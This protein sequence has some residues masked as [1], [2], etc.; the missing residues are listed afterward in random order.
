[1]SELGKR[2]SFNGETN[3]NNN[4]NKENENKV[5]EKEG[6]FDFLNII[7]DENTYNNNEFSVDNF[8]DFTKNN[9]IISNNDLFDYNLDNI[10]DN[11]T[12]TNFYDFTKFNNNPNYDIKNN[13][14]INTEQIENNNIG[15]LLF[16]DE[17]KDNE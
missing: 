17:N 16:F 6:I 5:V 13:N 12:T 11:S 7:N 1:M 2:K 9:N 15:N 14:T 8:F 3:L 10:N 4:E